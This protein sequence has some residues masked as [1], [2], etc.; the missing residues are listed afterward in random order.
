MSISCR[1][2]ESSIAYAD[3]VADLFLHGDSVTRIDSDAWS[4]ESV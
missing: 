1:D 4:N 3:D 2:C